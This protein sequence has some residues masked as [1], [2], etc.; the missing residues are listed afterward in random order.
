[1]ALSAH[2]HGFDNILAASHVSAAAGFFALM[3]RSVLLRRVAVLGE[4]ERD[5]IRDEGKSEGCGNGNEC[6]S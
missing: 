1:V 6:E 4:R 3:L 5:A 2:G